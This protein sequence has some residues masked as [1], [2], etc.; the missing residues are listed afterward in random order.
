MATGVSVD[1]LRSWPAVDD[2]P[3]LEWDEAFAQKE[4]ETRKYA[5]K[6]NEL[7]DANLVITF[8][9]GTKI[10]TKALVRK[11][12]LS[13]SQMSSSVIT[14]LAEPKTTCLIFAS[15]KG[16]I[17]G[18]KSVQH[19]LLAAWQVVRMVRE[20][21]IQGAAV[22][23]LRVRNVTSTAKMEGSVDIMK[24]EKNPGLLHW[25]DLQS[26]IFPGLYLK[27]LNKKIHITVAVFV[28]GK[29]NVTGAQDAS[30]T[31][32]QL[33]AVI[34][35]IRDCVVTDPSLR[36]ELEGRMQADRRER[37]GRAAKDKLKR[38]A[39][40]VARASAA[41][42][43]DPTEASAASSSAGGESNIASVPR[44]RARTTRA[45]DLPSAPGVRGS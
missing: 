16:L 21:G 9:F 37:H 1:E 41:A 25:A 29:V 24:L 8:N 43:S 42:G 11:A 31:E 5:V 33:N 34:R 15:G 13:T 4:Q 30:Q 44:K 38:H 22:N 32:E 20:C 45:P 17:V 23:G 3:P 6:A 36:K 2:V 18:V 40:S 7:V 26:N 19:G 28:S 39:E 10:S 27:P 14:K 12:P 35:Y